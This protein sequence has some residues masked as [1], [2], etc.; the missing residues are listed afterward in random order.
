MKTI[1][2]SLPP[3]LNSAPAPRVRLLGSGAPLVARATNLWRT[4]PVWRPDSARLNEVWVAL[5][6]AARTLSELAPLNTLAGAHLLIA[7]LDDPALTLAVPP[8]SVPIWWISVA[9]P[10]ARLGALGEEV[11]GA[12]REEG[13]VLRFVGPDQERTFLL[14]EGFPEEILI[15]ALAGLCVGHAFQ[16]PAHTLQR[17]LQYLATS[18][19]ST[20]AATRSIPTAPSVA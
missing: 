7:N 3:V 18:H 15:Q 10:Q 14:P 17:W 6:G 4:A 1:Y 20:P 13:D 2:R 16:L 11:H 9:P 5:D 12:W 19:A 8:S